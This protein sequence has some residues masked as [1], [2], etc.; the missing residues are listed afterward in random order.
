MIPLVAIKLKASKN[1]TPISE[2]LIGSLYCQGYEILNSQESAKDGEICFLTSS[3]PGFAFLATA[4]KKLKPEL[5]LDELLIRFYLHI[6]SIEKHKDGSGE[7]NL[8]HSDGLAVI[9]SKSRWQNYIQSIV[10]KAD[11]E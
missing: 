5:S 6:L 4:S 11:Q 9:G 3:K 7:V 1:I 10:I 8:C 2:I